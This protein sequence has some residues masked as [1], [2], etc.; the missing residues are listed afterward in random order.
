MYRQIKVAAISAKPRKWDKPGNADKLEQFFRRASRTKADLIVA[1]EAML[2][3]YVAME[4]IG[5]AQK[6][7]AMR[8]LAEP[9]NGPCIKRF[10]KLAGQLGRCLVFG[11][12]ERSGRNLYNT[13][14]FLDQRGRVCGRHRKTHLYEGSDATWWFNRIGRTL[15]AFDTPFGRAGMIICAERWN[16]DI[17][18]ALVLDGAQMLIIPSFGDR[19]KAQNETVLARA[20]ENGVPIVEASVGVNMIVSKGEMVAYKWGADEITT[21]TIDIP[22]PPS[23]RAARKAERAYL[24]WQGPEM[25]RRYRRTMKRVGKI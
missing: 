23:A 14:I 11:F 8:E 17:A 9:I 3:G 4:V 13:A 10:Q 24:K 15:R 12:T 2:D 5:D 18:R 1:P 6:A 25:S 19:S 16:P 21:A 7:A 20:R 22:F